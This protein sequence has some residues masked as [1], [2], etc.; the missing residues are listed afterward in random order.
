M[1]NIFK[2]RAKVLSTA[3]GR[4]VAFKAA[5]DYNSGLDAIDEIEPKQLAVVGFLTNELVARCAGIVEDEAELIKV[6]KNAAMD[7]T[8]A[9]IFGIPPGCRSR[10]AINTIM[11]SIK[12]IL[13]DPNKDNRIITEPEIMNICKSQIKL[14]LHADIYR[15]KNGLKTKFWEKWQGIYTKVMGS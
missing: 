8:E 7:Y 15:A 13:I 4:P 3:L 5:S 9:I 10:D 11:R 6:I 1:R 14:E 2:V 12:R